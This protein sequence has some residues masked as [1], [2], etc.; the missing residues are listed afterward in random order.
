MRKLKD[1]REAKLSERK[2]KGKEVESEK[3][4]R[5]EVGGPSGEGS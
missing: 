1:M 4:Q 5:K 2:R 3:R